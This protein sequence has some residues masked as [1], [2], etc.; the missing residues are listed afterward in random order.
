M[1]KLY[2]RKIKIQKIRKIILYIVLFP[3]KNTTNYLKK[4]KKKKRYNNINLTRT[5]FFVLNIKSIK[6]NMW[7]GFL[8]WLTILK[9]IFPRTVLCFGVEKK[10][11]KK[12][13]YFLC[14]EKT[15]NSEPTS[16]TPTQRSTSALSELSSQSESSNSHYDWYA[17]HEWTDWEPIRTN[18]RR[19]QQ[20]GNRPFCAVTCR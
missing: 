7:D 5:N 8:S 15:K 11:K 14:S 12:V 1:G 3:S 20:P 19:L 10:R 4:K 13:A 9:Q 2:I 18:P 16:A 17:E 6:V